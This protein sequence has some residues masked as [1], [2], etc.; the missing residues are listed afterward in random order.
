MKRIAPIVVAALASLSSFAQQPPQAASASAAE[1]PPKAIAIINGD[2]I[3]ADKLD[4]LYTHMNAQMR[5]QYEKSGGKGAFL[6][7][8]LRKRL[9]VQEAIKHGFD[10]RPDV[11]AEMESAKESALFE[12]YIREEVSKSVIP[13]AEL[14]TYYKEHQSDF[15]TPEA[16]NVRHII[17]MVN[18][19][20]PRPK[21]KQQAADLIERIAADLHEAANAASTPEGKIQVLRTR[22]ADAARKYSED[23]V[24]TD[25]GSLGW[26]ER[27]KFDPKFEEVA[28]SL[29][30]G[31]VSPVVETPFGY[32]LIFVDAKRPAAIQPFDRVRRE[33]RE[34]LQSKRM[35]EI[36][37]AVTK[38]SNELR[39][40]SKISM[41][42]ENLR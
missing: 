1:A 6:D 12:A 16:V 38:L 29:P 40:D 15:G 3:S 26:S 36:M 25:G 23:G 22:F 42:P 20:G 39:S 2:V 32:H 27:G 33:I 13:E 14:E 34:Y 41:F 8:Y 28:F 10:K 30:I 5:A 7:N 24:A 21:S 18:G 37:Q 4:F 35:S 11:Q 19:A 31:T 9:I 17:I